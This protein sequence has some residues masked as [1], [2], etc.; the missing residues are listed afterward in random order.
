MK[1]DREGIVLWFLNLAF[2]AFLLGIF[3]LIVY[4]IVTGHP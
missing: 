1:D 2:P 3:A 4:C